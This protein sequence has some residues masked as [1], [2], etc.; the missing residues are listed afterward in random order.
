MVELSKFAYLPETI[1][2]IT[3]EFVIIVGLFYYKYIYKVCRLDQNDS[4][5]TTK[6]EDSYRSFSPFLTYILF[7]TRTLSL[8]YIL[9]ISVIVNDIIYWGGW[10]FFT[11]WNTTLISIYFMFSM[12][13]SIVGLI[14]DNPTNIVLNQTRN[15]RNSQENK[16]IWSSR[17]S[18]CSRLLLGLFS[19]CGGTAILVTVYIFMHKYTYIYICMNIHI[20]IYM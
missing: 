13:C 20:Y 17:V 16:S 11:N 7:V 18:Y 8:G 12:S 15:E 19:I 6:F 10:Y 3:L 5:Q 4:Q 14:Y 9:G 2:L 1:L